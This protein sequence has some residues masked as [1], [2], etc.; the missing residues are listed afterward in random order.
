MDQF[1]VADIHRQVRHAYDALWLLDATR[2]IA[3][4]SEPSEP[5]EYLYKLQG[6]APGSP[7]WNN[8]DASIVELERKRAIKDV[9]R[10]LR[11]KT[12]KDLGENPDPW[13]R[14]Y[15][16]EYIKHLQTNFDPNPSPRP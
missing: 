11:T 6:A 8:V 16:P 15:G 13:I 14:E 2:D 7:V 4:R 9:I 3:L 12:G 10:Y 5:V 1:N